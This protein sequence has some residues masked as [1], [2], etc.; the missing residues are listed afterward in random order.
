MCDMWLNFIRDEHRELTP[1]SKFIVIRLAHCCAKH[2]SVEGNSVKALSKKFGVSD[3]T[4]SMAL[5]WLIENKYLDRARGNFSESFTEKCIENEA[6]RVG[7]T[8]AKAIEHLLVNRE[9]T[10]LLKCTA[11]RMF[12]IVL[13]AHADE[14]GVVSKLS[15]AKLERI[16]GSFSKDRHRAQV[17]FFMQKSIL[18]GYSPGFTG[19]YLFGKQ[20]SAYLINLQHSLFEK[21][22]AKRHKMEVAQLSSD[23]MEMIGFG[24]NR[25]IYAPDI[26]LARGR[27]FKFDSLT[28]TWSEDEKEKWSWAI[29]H[30]RHFFEGD[31]IDLRL[32]QYLFNLA[33]VD[34]KSGAQDLCPE[35]LLSPAYLKNVRKIS[36]DQKIDTVQEALNHVIKDNSLSVVEKLGSDIYKQLGALGYVLSRLSVSLAERYGK[37]ISVSGD[38]SREVFF[39]VW[40]GD[41]RLIV[42][43]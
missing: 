39:S 14:F 29:E 8:W 35:H 10:E 16:L 36:D 18:H 3:R 22:N 25:S 5:D 11:R 33:M 42:W 28:E 20:K 1:E 12:L 9:E 4:V 30:S 31:S 7:E 23:Q 37:Y 2:E 6:D 43:K 26:K 41:Y 38:F 13:L 32:C 40:K 19:K 21:V 15:M 24:V 17:D 27:G 34:K